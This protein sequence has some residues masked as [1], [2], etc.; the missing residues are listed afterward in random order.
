MAALS[1][2]EQNLIEILVQAKLVGVDETKRA[3][4]KLT[5]ELSNLGIEAVKTKTGQTLIRDVESKKLV[6]LSPQYKEQLKGL[7]DSL[8]H[9]RIADLRK[10][11]D[12]GATSARAFNRA[13]VDLG[14]AYG[15]TDKEIQK[16]IVSTEKVQQ[17]HW[18]LAMR[19]I[20]V[21]PIWMALRA[22]YSSVI[23]TVQQGV[24]NMVEFDKA[25]ARA[26]T[27]V[28][29]VTDVSDFM[30]TLAANVRSLVQETGVSA[31]D[32]TEA[33]YRFGSTGLDAATSLAGM[34]TAIKMS[35]ALMGDSTETARILADLYV[36]LGDS[37]TSVN[38][39]QE[40][41]NYLASTIALLWRD[42]T[43]ELNEFTEGLKNFAATAS[44]FNLSVE[45]MMGLLAATHTLMQRGGAGGTQ[46]SRV[47]IQLAQNTKVIGRYLEDDADALIRTRG[48]FEVFSMVVEKM[49]RELQQ[50]IP[51]MDEVVDIFDIRASKA[52][53]GFAKQWD[54]V[55]KQLRTASLAP[56]EK[57]KQF[58]DLLNTAIDTVD[59]Q[60]KIMGQLRNQT[61][62]AFAMSITGA[63][64][65]L[66]ALKRINGFL[67]NNLIPTSMYFGITFRRAVE[68]VKGLFNFNKKV[69]FQDVLKQSLFG[70]V[71][72]LIETQTGKGID[73]LKGLVLS[74]VP[75]MI[76]TEKGIRE[77]YNKA[78]NDFRTK[79]KSE[80]A[81]GKVRLLQGLGLNEEEA[82]KYLD[83]LDEIIY[84]QS[85]MNA[86]IDE[87]QAK[88]DENDKNH[89]KGQI[90]IGVVERDISKTLEYQLLLKD[91]LKMFGYTD[92]QIE[93]EKL[94][95]LT[96]SNQRIDQ[97]IK[98]AKMSQDE[99]ENYASAIKGSL[100]TSVADIFKGTAGVEDVFV[101]LG[102]KI[103]DTLIDVFA[104]LFVNKFLDAT[105]FAGIFGS[106]IAAMKDAL[107]TAMLSSSQTAGQ[108]I[109]SNII[110]ASQKGAMLFYNAITAAKP[111][112]A[113]GGQGAAPPPEKAPPSSTASYTGTGG[114]VGGAVVVPAG[115]PGGTTGTTIPATTDTSKA[116]SLKKQQSDL[117]ANKYK[118]GESLAFGGI[119]AALT[120]YSTYQSA[121]AGGV[122]RGRAIGAGVMAAGGAIAG[123]AAMSVGLTTT[124]AAATGAAAAG[125]SS[126]AA[127]SGSIGAANAWN[128]VG[129]VLLIIAAI[130]MIGSIF[131]AQGKKAKANQ[132][133]QQTTEN[134][135]SSRINV[136]NKNLEIINRNLI[137]LRSD[138]RTYMLPASAYFA[139]KRGIEDEFSIM[140]R[141]GF[142]GGT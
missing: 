26:K 40:K 39:P 6:G 18:K 106:T 103:R 57:Q 84:R 25:L 132:Q 81:T 111:G 7:S 36:L 71:G 11:L 100:T 114:A 38:T 115:T 92:L 37:I 65:F 141:R 2:A 50:G 13:I 14:R 43:F 12:L 127:T 51:I 67:R 4:L 24:Q 46:L 89:L 110:S 139:E 3:V 85:K 5:K 135:I 20:Q 10:D 47:F 59:R 48:Y 55:T 123:I 49:N 61:V 107:G 109:S 45:Q 68:E 129:W 126:A 112:S 53:A 58:D 21:I 60:I 64:D 95:L 94:S 76:A 74:K 52:V 62:E 16:Y 134:Q 72:G 23:N 108:T 105:G 128:P 73:K 82:V 66:E 80:E 93:R 130:L 121:T 137:A 98:L 42:N 32:A 29:G 54:L 15:L 78:W 87:K 44:N 90:G 131:M 99:A 34:N 124:T 142:Q 17:S 70:P 83:V 75:P 113:V 69:S 41:M 133:Q 125:A 122:P 140:S 120:G 91:R 1:K 8:L 96:D 136:T 116:T 56:A 33:F 102:N 30:K 27:V 28:K 22:A 77:E 19:A 117:K 101:N 138:I 9:T 86:D 79:F 104:E 35:I 119:T 63:G 88:Q 31:A 118:L 97:Q